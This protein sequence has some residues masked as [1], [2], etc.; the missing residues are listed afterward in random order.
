MSSTKD[1]LRNA[2]YELLLINAFLSSV[3]VIIVIGYSYIPEVIDLADRRHQQFMDTIQRTVRNS[4]SICILSTIIA[5][6]TPIL[7]VRHLKR[8]KEKRNLTSNPTS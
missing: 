5:T 6:V 1:K 8:N 2:I 4:L 3:I 7:L